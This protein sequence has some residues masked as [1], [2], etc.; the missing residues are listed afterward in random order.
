MR[1]YEKLMVILYFIGVL[2]AGSDSDTIWPWN[3]LAGA[4]I[5]GLVYVGVLIIEK[6]SSADHGH[7][8]D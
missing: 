6:K 4:G 2:V 1:R 8:G 5:L 3:V 7:S